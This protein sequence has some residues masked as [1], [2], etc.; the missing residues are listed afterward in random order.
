MSELKS[1]EPDKVE[2]SGEVIKSFALAFPEEIRDFGLEILN[3]HGV[4]DP[5]PNR[6]YLAQPFLDAM[7]EVGQRL[8]RN[9][10]TRLGERVSMSVA[11]PPEWDTLETALSG[12]S[13]A[14]H[15]KYRGG[16]IGDWSYVRMGTNGGLTRCKMISSNHYCCA[17][18]RGV[19]EGF[20]QRFRPT[21]VTD[22]LVRHD[23]SQPCR[24]DGGESCTYI[25]TWG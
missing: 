2:V 22:V 23:D 24:K 15:L 25:I 12:M 13:S 7:L 9:W 4:K 14:Y 6:F 19:L 17:F 8:G 11:L 21:G 20:A 3:K 10:M 18:D 1:Y 5:E 16:E